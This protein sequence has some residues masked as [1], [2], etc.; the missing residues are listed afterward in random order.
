M[1]PKSEYREPTCYATTVIEITMPI[2]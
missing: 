2:V 1:E